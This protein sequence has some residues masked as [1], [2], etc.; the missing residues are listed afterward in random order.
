MSKLINI[1]RISE[2]SAGYK[3]NKPKYINNKQCLTNFVSKFGTDNLYVFADNTSNDTDNMICEITGNNPIKISRGS[4]GQSFRH[5][6][7][8]VLNQNFNVDDIIYFIES[9]YIH[10][11]GSREALIEGIN[12][13]AHF[14]TLYTHPDKFINASDGGNP[15]IEGG[16]EITR[17]IKTDSCFWMFTNSTTMTFAA[18]IKTLRE[19]KY[20]I[21][22]HTKGTYPTDYDMFIELRLLDKVLIQPL[23]AYST[24]GETRWLSTPRKGI[25][26]NLEQEWEKII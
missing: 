6:Y 11:D 1:Y 19:C 24:H 15:E 14:V 12:S 5:V 8:W 4:S 20:L 16:G 21:E 23:P 2:E 18:T 9:D 3:K 22:K 17:V 10:C 25:I 7:D 13:G 26:D